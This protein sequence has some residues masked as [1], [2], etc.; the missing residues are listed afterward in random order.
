MESRVKAK[1]NK[2][3]FQIN[4]EPYAYIELCNSWYQNELIDDFHKRISV[5]GEMYEIDRMNFAKRGCSDDA[6]L[7]EVVDIHTGTESQSEEVNKILENSRF[8]VMYRKQLERMS[9]AGTVAAYVRLDNA[10]Y[11][12][13]GRI[14]G[15]TVKLSWCYAENYIPLNVVNA[16]VI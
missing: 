10:T 3:G 15:G 9:A 2:L 16:N 8:D 6:N 7:C 12:D 4:T 11:L 13:N 5:N 14:T 1:L